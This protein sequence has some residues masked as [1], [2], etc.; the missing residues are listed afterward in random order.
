MRIKKEKIKS[1][2][3]KTRRNLKKAWRKFKYLDKLQF[4]YFIITSFIGAFCLFTGVTY[5]AFTI[6]KK[7]NAA[8]ITIAKLNYT[9][10]ENGTSTGYNNGSVSVGAGET[11]TLN[12]RLTSSNVSET[13]YALNYIE[14]QGIQVYYSHNNNLI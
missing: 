12:L 4:N 6:S 9:L 10:A 11:V 3:I 8:V 5:S 1:L 7:L 13:R 14:Q 2:Y